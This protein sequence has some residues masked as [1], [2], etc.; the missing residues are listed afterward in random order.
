MKRRTKK[1][2]EGGIGGA[3]PAIAHRR[4]RTSDRCS[5][6]SGKSVDHHRRVL[7]LLQFVD[8][9]FLLSIV[10]FLYVRFIF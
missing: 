2:A 8:L 10:A 7:P 1:H 5:C 9:R 4:R 6:F 3:P